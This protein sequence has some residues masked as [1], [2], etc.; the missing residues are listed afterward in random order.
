MT[1]KERILEFIS[2]NN[3]TVRGFERAAG[4]SNGAVSKM[5]D[6]PRSSVVQKITSTFV[7][8]NQ[9]WLLTGRGEMMQQRAIIS[10]DPGAP[11][12]PY[13]EEDFTLGFDELIPPSSEHP[14]FLVRMPG[15][16]RATLWC[17]AS[18]NS[19]EPEIG[20]G[21]VVALQLIN[22]ISFLPFG[23]IF[24]FVTTNGMRTIKR[25]GKSKT[26]G[27]IRL[28]PTNPEYDEQDL[29]L[30][31]IIRAFKVMGSLKHF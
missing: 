11:G 29:P 31:K 23:D 19:M 27:C 8:L 9:Q 10:T 3:L 4:L 30:T 28:I 2:S 5:G 14:A 13:Y 17:R 21:D 18:G 22:D 6:N 16:E 24:A 25:V 26:P 7:D 15:F 20:N 1:V 12:V